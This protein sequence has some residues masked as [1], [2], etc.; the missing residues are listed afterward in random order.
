MPA[1]RS[2]ASACGISMLSYEINELE[3]FDA[4]ISLIGECRGI[5]LSPGCSAG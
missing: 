3:A 4:L 1:Y 2:E 5:R